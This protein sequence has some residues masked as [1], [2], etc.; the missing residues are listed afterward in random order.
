MIGLRLGDVHSQSCSPD[1][2]PDQGNPQN[3]ELSSHFSSSFRKV[4][5]MHSQVC[6]FALGGQHDLSLKSPSSFQHQVAWKPSISPSWSQRIL[7]YFLHISSK[8]SQLSAT[9]GEKQA[10]ALCPSACQ[11]LIDN[12]LGSSS[13]FQGERG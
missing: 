6:G 12:S 7:P 10:F 8:M 11:I 5:H 13:F 3:T 4:Y 1:L 9:P 2:A